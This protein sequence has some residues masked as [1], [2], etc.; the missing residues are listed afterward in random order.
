MAAGQQWVLTAM[1]D[2]TTPGMICVKANRA[3]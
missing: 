1:P 2:A 3:H